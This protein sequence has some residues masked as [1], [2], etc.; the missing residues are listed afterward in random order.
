MEIS[1]TVRRG[2]DDQPLTFSFLAPAVQAALRWMLG[3]TVFFDPGFV[4]CVHAL[5]GLDG[6]RMRIFEEV[7]RVQNVALPAAWAQLQLPPVASSRRVP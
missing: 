3:S 1:F 7:D 2:S 5:C 4:A 6:V